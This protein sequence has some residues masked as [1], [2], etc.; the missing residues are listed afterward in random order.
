MAINDNLIAMYQFNGNANDWSGSNANG[1]VNG[2]TLTTDRFGNA[3]SAYIFDWNDLITCNNAIWAI[4]QEFTLSAWVYATSIATWTK[5]I[6]ISNTDRFWMWLISGTSFQLYVHDWWYKILLVPYTSLPWWS[7]LN[8]WTHCLIAFKEGIL[9]FYSDGQFISQLSWIGTI[10][11]WN[12]LLIWN[13]SSLAQWFIWTIDDCK[14]YNRALSDAEIQTLYKIWAWN[15]SL[16]S[17]GEY[18]TNTVSNLWVDTTWLV[19]LYKFNWNANDWSGLWNHGIVNIATLTTDRYG[20]ANSAYE[21]LWT[22]SAADINSYISLWATMIGSAED[23]TISTVIKSNSNSI[24]HHI[25]RRNSEFIMQYVWGKLH[26]AVY[27]ESDSGYFA[28]ECTPPTVWTYFNLTCRCTFSWGNTT[29]QIFIDGVIQ[30]WE[31][32][33]SWIR[34]NA[35]TGLYIFNWAFHPFSWVMDEFYVFSRALTNTE[36]MQLSNVQQ[37]VVSLKAWKT[38][39]WFLDTNTPPI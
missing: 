12:N 7:I 31:I 23:F 37:G 6:F 19:G 5:R 8:R 38:Y 22:W 18:L 11:W 24:R 29:L 27:R 36:I 20:N 17:T 32:T 35:N 34:K 2:A 13:W 21:S 30:P 33:F 9:K 4:W 26:F 28:A 1:T 10:A 25:Y 39:A 16:L 14:V 15:H 3:N